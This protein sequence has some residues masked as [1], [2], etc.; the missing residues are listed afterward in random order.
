M[1]EQAQCPGLSVWTTEEK[2]RAQKL[3]GLFRATQASDAAR[4][5][6]QHGPL[7]TSDVPCSSLSPHVAIRHLVC[8]AHLMHYGF[9]THM[10]GFK[11]LEEKT[12]YKSM[13]LM[14]CY[15]SNVLA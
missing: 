4:L 13:A 3:C 9:K 10:L 1:G 7:P 8:V 12:K 2:T 6:S 14:L 5:G 15:I 11:E